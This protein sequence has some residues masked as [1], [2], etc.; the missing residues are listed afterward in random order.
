[1]KKILYIFLA[2]A[3]ALTACRQIDPD[4]PL[5]VEK[6]NQD[7]KV[8][9]E[10]NIAVPTDGVSTKAMANKPQIQ[11]IV[12]AVFGGS[13]YFNEWVQADAKTVYATENEV[14]YK[15]SAKLSMS[16]SRL[17]IHVIANCPDEFLA[18]PPI[19]GVSSEDLED[20]VISKI[21]SKIT[22]DNNDGYWQKFYLPY[23][24][25]AE[26]DPNGNG[27]NAYLIDDDGNLIPTTLT[28]NQ[29]KMVS[30]IP[31]VRNFARIKLQNL[32]DDVTIYKI[33][34]AYA[35]AEGVIAPILPRPYKVDEWGARVAEVETGGDDT[36]DG[37]FKVYPVKTDGVFG[38]DYGASLPEMPVLP[39][40]PTEEQISNY[41]EAME[42]YNTQ[43]QSYIPA[44]HVL[45]HELK[46][47]TTGADVLLEEVKGSV[48]EES[49]L[50]NYQNLPLNAAATLSDG[51]TYKLITDAPY[52]Y[53]GT[54]SANLLFASNPTSNTDGTPATGFVDYDSDGY[55]YVY[56]RPKPRTF[57]GKTEKATRIIIYAEKTGEQAKYY[58]LDILDSKGD[59]L[60]LL[61]NF[62]YNV[63][64]AS[65]AT[66]SGEL[67]AEKA[68]D[69][70]GANVSSDPNTQDLNEVSDGVSTIRVSYIDITYIKAGTYSV[71]YQFIP[72]KNGGQ[73]NKDVTIDWGYDGGE[74]GYASH[75]VSANG[76]PFAMTPATE[77]EPNGVPTNL[78]IEMDDTT[79]KLYVPDG[80]SW[81][82]A[83]T[84]AEKAAAWSRIEYT[85]IGTEG[86]AF[87]V[88]TFGTIRVTGS[89]ANGSLYRDVRVNV[90]PKKTMTVR[91]AQKYVQSIAGQPEDYVI[92]I[93]ADIT[94][95]MFPLEF[96]V[97]AAAASITP[98]DGDN[99]PVQ[100]G[101]SIVENQETR[102][103]FFFIK[104]LTRQEYE[105]ETK[106]PTIIVDGK[107]YKEFTCHFKTTKANSAT[108]I[109]AYNEYFNLAHDDFENF[110]QR[111]FTTNPTDIG[112]ISIGEEKTLTLIM[113]NASRTNDNN[114]VWDNVE[115][116]FSD[117]NQVI[118]H[119]VKLTMVGIQPKTD[120]TG[121]IV[122]TGLTASL[123]EDGVYYYKPSA[124]GSR[125]G[126]YY[127]DLSL[128][129]ENGSEDAYSITFSTATCD[130]PNLYADL[131]L[132]GQITKSRITDIGF[133]NTSGNAISSIG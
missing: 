119:E 21:R 81:K 66:G 42:Q 87:D 90:I 45:G 55:L 122:T 105:D 126:E 88:N 98:R 3:L 63:S 12:L 47:A 82:M 16:E 28:V 75:A 52:S 127:K 117:S 2:V 95:S 89:R 13:G 31:L 125:P 54:A 29:F 51:N 102:S 24:I 130:N 68:A 72:T 85:T 128:V 53:S 73:S 60:P 65:I 61:R 129:I 23:G 17:R 84:D 37:S 36:H 104:T 48:Y 7:L 32:A 106:T 15:L 96:K 124:S 110:K 97:E 77:A 78:K 80:N 74:N 59:Y 9:I 103:S 123:N 99:L 1:M 4:A 133:T 34:L 27:S 70:T 62:T 56:E 41:N 46:N 11:N 91:C 112:D 40:N 5:P 76:S 44:L 39:D 38:S 49:F 35:P 25:A 93:P 33:G 19:T 26:I 64:L 20:V 10:F 22:E 116:G 43:M 83:T 131:T 57:S 69:A 100:S 114:M 118:P 113:D 71:Y 58:A 101:K 120:A 111:L 94:R 115:E 92:R 121:H 30:P 109:Y 67:T 6:V 50:T 18:S 86:E 14:V 107:P 79:P 108:T 132:S 8:P